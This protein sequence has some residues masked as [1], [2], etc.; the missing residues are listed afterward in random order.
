MAH[1]TGNA[2]LTCLVL[3]LWCL[4]PIRLSAAESRPN[5]LFILTDDQR[6]DALGV[7]QREQG[8][9]S[10][11]PWLKTPNL[12]KLANEGVRFR[13]AF[14]VNSLCAPSRASFLSGLYG[15]Q[16]G[17]FNNT[18]PFP[19][20]AV[21][22]AS[23]LR[24]AGYKTGYVG[25]WHMGQQR[26]RPGF[27]YAA[28]YTGQGKYPDCTFLVNG[29]PVETEGWVDDVATDYALGFLRE[30]KSKPFVLAVGYKAAHSPFKPPERYKNTYQKE[31]VR[32]VPNLELLPPFPM[33][34]GP[35]VK[36]AQ[37]FAGGNAE[38]LVNYMACLTAV[39]ENIGKIMSELDQLGVADDTVVVFA[40]D[41]GFYFREHGLGD[42][43]SAYE[44]SLRI[45]LLVRYPKLIKKGMLIDEM[46]LNIDLAPT[47]I[48]MAGIQVPR[49]MQGQSW[50]RLFKGDPAGWR[51]SFYYEYFHEPPFAS[52]HVQALRTDTAKLIHYPG[53]P[54]WAEL[55]DL[56]AD[57]YETKNLRDD[58]A[59]AELRRA[60]ETELEQQ[61]ARLEKEG[62]KVKP[63]GRIE[64]VPGI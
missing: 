16:I 5:F 10:R 58:P 28:S 2:K 9:K 1:A 3:L 30:N 57:P 41:N 45:P 17:V 25:K 42:K 29:K 13:N 19:A 11:F 21:T 62:L 55:F 47:F 14:V 56:A 48:E 59:K 64:P 49:H 23:V 15:H 53:H 20:E 6:W 60:L 24:S 46:V 31:K 63:A 8:D 39:D 34:K 35:E 52:P 7:V 27:D 18:T 36:V 12:D 26:E 37:V 51:S 54:E 61:R 33:T 32:P 44:E 40:G 43:R 38:I 50:L 4:L 22:Y